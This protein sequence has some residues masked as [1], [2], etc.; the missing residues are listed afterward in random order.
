LLQKETETHEDL[1]SKVS[2]E[3]DHYEKRISDLTF[4]MEF[5]EKQAAAG[6]KFELGFDRAVMQN[7]WLT[8]GPV[9]EHMKFRADLF[10]T[11]PQV[12]LWRSFHAQR[13]G[14]P[15]QARMDDGVPPSRS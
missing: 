13:W 6:A 12:E 9:V 2:K 15:G 14:L 1:I 3:R 4:Y 10:N 7:K 8:E 11:S 5:F